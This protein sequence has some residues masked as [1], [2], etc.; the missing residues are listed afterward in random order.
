MLLGNLGSS[1]LGHLLTVKVQLG[2]VK[3]FNA[4]SFI[5]KFWNTKVLSK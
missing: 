2:K 3:I 5:S 1:L 4:D